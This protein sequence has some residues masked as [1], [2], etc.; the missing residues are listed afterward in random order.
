M[1]GS[2]ESPASASVHYSFGM[3]YFFLSKLSLEIDCKMFWSS[4]VSMLN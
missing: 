3:E 2:Y 1:P 4:R